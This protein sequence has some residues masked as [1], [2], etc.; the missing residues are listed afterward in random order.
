MAQSMRGK[1]YIHTFVLIV[2]W[3]SLLTTVS[4]TNYAYFCNQGLLLLWPLTDAPGVVTLVFIVLALYLPG[5]MAFVFVSAGIV[6][7]VSLSNAFIFGGVFGGNIAWR[8]EVAYGN[9]LWEWLNIVVVQETPSAVVRIYPTFHAVR[10]VIW[11]AA[12]V[13][14]TYVLRRS[15]QKARDLCRHVTFPPGTWPFGVKPKDRR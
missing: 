8:I 6:C 10:L 2:G 15:L 9:A 11:I 1:P 12:G 4:V 7:C 5:R 13:V 3:L 14:T